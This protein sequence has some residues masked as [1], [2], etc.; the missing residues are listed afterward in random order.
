[1]AI[2]S[3]KTVTVFVSDQDAARDFYVEA[4]GLEVKADQTFGD[5][6][7]LEV[8]A[9]QGT[10]LVLHKPFPGMS[11]GGGQGTLLASDHL[12]AD[13]ARLRAAGVVVDGPNEMPWGTQATFS[14]LDGNG[15]V[16][17]G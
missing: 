13:V 5:N 7:W 4:L 8:G 9:P 6:R 10:T 1:M 2:N 14:D 15:Y 11:A 16:L 12:D 3:V 17:Q